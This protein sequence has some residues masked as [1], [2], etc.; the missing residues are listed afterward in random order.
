MTCV[1]LLVSQI[2]WTGLL[3][4]SVLITLKMNYQNRGWLFSCQSTGLLAEKYL[5]I[6][7]TQTSVCW[8]EE[9]SEKTEGSWFFLILSHKGH[10]NPGQERTGQPQSFQAGRQGASVTT[11]TPSIAGCLST[12]DRSYPPRTHTLRSPNPRPLP[13]HNCHLT[14]ASRKLFYQKTW[15]SA[16]TKA[17]NCQGLTLC[18]YLAAAWQTPIPTVGLSEARHSSSPLAALIWEQYTVCAN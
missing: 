1:A 6:Y 16:L 7:Y 3:T 9:K 11:P 4:S 10:H 2:N 17:R 14:S 13:C 12:S 8:C 15:G 18:V 5:I